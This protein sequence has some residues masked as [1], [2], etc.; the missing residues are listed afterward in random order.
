[1]NRYKRCRAG[2]LNSMAGTSKVQFVGEPCSQEVG[3]ITDI[4]L[5]VVEIAQ[6]TRVGCEVKDKV[7][8]NSRSGKNPYRSL[9]SVGVMAG[10]FQGRP[11]ALE[12]DSVLG[13]H[14]LSLFVTDAEQ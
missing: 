4:E 7:R 6:E 10:I 5:A 8:V 3:A 12:E 1:M 14:Y 9:E 13:I 2:T 11:A